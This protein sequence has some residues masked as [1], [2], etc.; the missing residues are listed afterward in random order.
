MENSQLNFLILIEGMCRLLSSFVINLGVQD[1]IMIV[2]KPRTVRNNRWDSVCYRLDP[3]TV[4]SKTSMCC[5]RSLQLCY[6]P[7][8]LPTK[9]VYS[10]C[11]P[12]DF[13]LRIKLNNEVLAWLDSSHSIKSPEISFEKCFINGGVMVVLLK[14]TSLSP[15]FITVRFLSG[16][17]FLGTDTRRLERAPARGVAFSCTLWGVGE[18]LCFHC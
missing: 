6:H 8:K 5:A 13:W 14:T 11:I 9:I 4:N 12:S 18:R 3:T 15:S 16:I 10:R 2:E 17:C 1:A 7:F